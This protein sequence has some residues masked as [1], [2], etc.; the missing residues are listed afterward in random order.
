MPKKKASFDKILGYLDLGLLIS[1]VPGISSSTTGQAKSSIKDPSK[2]PSGCQNKDLKLSLRNHAFMDWKHIVFLHWIWVVHEMIEMYNKHM[3]SM[4][5][6]GSVLY[7]DQSMSSWDSML[8]CSG[9]VF[10]PW[11]PQLIYNDCYTFRY[12]QSWVFMQIDLEDGKDHP[13]ELTNPLFHKKN[14]SYN[15]TIFNF[16]PICHTWF[17]FLWF[18]GNCSVEI[19]RYI[20]WNIDQK[21]W[22]LVSNSSWQ[23]RWI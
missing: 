5:V 18:E 19:E 16:V 3:A 6:P 10:C 1:T 13:K 22:I 20:C 2:F 11:K 8:T 7:L 12:A 4:F 15:A 17:C 9:W 23:S 14:K 21:A